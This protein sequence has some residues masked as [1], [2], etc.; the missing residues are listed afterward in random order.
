[1]WTAALLATAAVGLG[2]CSLISANHERSFPQPEGVT[3]D[4]NCEGW[5]SLDRDV[6]LAYAMHRLAEMRASDGID[7]AARPPDDSQGRLLLS[8]M[9]AQCRMDSMDVA[10]IWRVAHDQYTRLYHRR[11]LLD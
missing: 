6:R 7:P 10:A 3:Q 2:S 5:M 1:M 4:T 11:V 8:H 9:E